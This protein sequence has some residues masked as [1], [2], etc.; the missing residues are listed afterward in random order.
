[1]VCSRSWEVE[2][3]EQPKELGGTDSSSKLCA[4]A[5]YKGRVRGPV[6]PVPPAGPRRCW[7]RGSI[8]ANHPIDKPN[9][10][11]YP[12]FALWEPLPASRANLVLSNTFMVY[13]CANL[14]P[15]ISVRHMLV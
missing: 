9:K 1:M 11:G 2:E 12:V 6:P 5:L 10:L 15:H 7:V 8:R 3:Q 4:C 13:R 14:L